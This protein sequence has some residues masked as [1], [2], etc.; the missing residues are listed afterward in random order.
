[1]DWQNWKLKLFTIAPVSVA[2]NNGASFRACL[3]VIF[4]YGCPANHTIRSKGTFLSAIIA[5]NMLRA[6]LK[7]LFSTK[8]TTN[9]SGFCFISPPL[10]FSRAGFP[11]VDTTIGFVVIKDFT[12]GRT[13]YLYFSHVTCAVSLTAKFI[14]HAF[15]KKRV[16]NISGLLNVGGWYPHAPIIPI[17][18]RINLKPIKFRESLCQPLIFQFSKLLCGDLNTCL[19]PRPIIANETSQDNG[20]FNLFYKFIA[21]YFLSVWIKQLAKLREARSRDCMKSAA[22]ANFSVSFI[23]IGRKINW[24]G[25]RLQPFPFLSKPVKLFFRVVTG[26]MIISASFGLI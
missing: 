2:Q 10:I 26:Q 8:E 12:A 13:L 4:G 24:T 25:V 7:H 21:D 16:A 23:K 1:M 14:V 15:E 3:P 20:V 17:D 18:T 9:H 22:L 5:P 11:A 19:V 6:I